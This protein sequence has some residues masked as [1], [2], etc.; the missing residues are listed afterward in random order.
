MFSPPSFNINSYRKIAGLFV[1]I[2]EENSITRTE[3]INPRMV[4]YG[5][6]C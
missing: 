6:L 4:L 3:S 5:L 1:P 2:G